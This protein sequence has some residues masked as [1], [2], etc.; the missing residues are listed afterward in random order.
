MYDNGTISVCVC[1][2]VCARAHYLED[3]VGAEE[4]VE[5]EHHHQHIQP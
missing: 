2:C 5:K 3:H 4:D 1:V